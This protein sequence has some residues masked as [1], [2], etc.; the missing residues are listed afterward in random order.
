MSNTKEG[1]KHTNIEIKEEEEE[2]S[3]TLEDNIDEA[4]RTGVLGTAGNYHVN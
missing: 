1:D 2:V 4:L 3:N